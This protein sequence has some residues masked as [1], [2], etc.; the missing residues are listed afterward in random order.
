MAIFIIL[1][2]YPY[3]SFDNHLN[4]FRINGHCSDQSKTIY[5][6]DSNSKYLIRNSNYKIPL[7]KKDL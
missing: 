5:T 2:L 3:I 7:K 4:G 6:D 1:K